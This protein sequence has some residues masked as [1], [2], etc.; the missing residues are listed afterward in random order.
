VYSLLTT[1][2]SLIYKSPLVPTQLL[3]ATAIP[4]H[5][6]KQ[7]FDLQQILFAIKAGVF[8]NYFDAYVSRTNHDVHVSLT[9]Y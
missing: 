2:Y 1:N 6:Y 9:V 3:P 8:S 7:P 4:L 5:P